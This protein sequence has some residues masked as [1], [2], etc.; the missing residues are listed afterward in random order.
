VV[1][2]N[3]DEL[4]DICICKALSPTVLDHHRL[5]WELAYAWESMENSM[6][7]FMDKT[8]FNITHGL[9]KALRTRVPH[10]LFTISEEHHT[11]YRFPLSHAKCDSN[12]IFLMK[13]SLSSHL[14]L[15]EN[16]TLPTNFYQGLRHIRLDA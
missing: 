13:I 16:D 3:H 7:V 15:H 1:P 8:W 10:I 12:K 14:S 11:L 2:R 6:R 5:S 4:I 9:F